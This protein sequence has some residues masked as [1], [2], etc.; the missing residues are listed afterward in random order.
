MSSFQPLRAYVRLSFSEGSKLY[1]IL[2]RN[3]R[4]SEKPSENLKRI[5]LRYDQLLENA[6]PPS[7][8]T[9]VKL[10]QILMQTGFDTLFQNTY[11]TKTEVCNLVAQVAMPQEDI[12]SV[13]NQIDVMTFTDFAKLIEAVENYYNGS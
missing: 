4:E 11:P 6:T 10:G 7:P 8:N 9:V 13:I 12:N 5:V 3:Q 1:N 2:R